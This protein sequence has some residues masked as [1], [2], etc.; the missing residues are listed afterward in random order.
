MTESLAEQI[1]TIQEKLKERDDAALK[2]AE[3]EFRATMEKDTAGTVLGIFRGIQVQLAS[4]QAQL[5]AS[6]PLV[7]LMRAFNAT[8]AKLTEIDARLT[9]LEAT[10][11]MEK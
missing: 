5:D 4:I 9:K 7:P 11:K 8:T 1:K 10:P 6:N 3:K 2:Q